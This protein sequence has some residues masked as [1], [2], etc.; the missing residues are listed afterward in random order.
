MRKVP[1]TF[2]MRLDL[3]MKFSELFSKTC[4]NRLRQVQICV[5]V[6]TG[7]EVPGQGNSRACRVDVVGHSSS[8]MHLL[9]VMMHG[10]LRWVCNDSLGLRESLGQSVTYDHD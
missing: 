7:A 10:K 6:Q 4:G 8:T 2:I 1:S 5:E 9:M 3:S